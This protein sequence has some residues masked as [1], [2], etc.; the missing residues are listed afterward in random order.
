MTR[1]DA[2]AMEGP[3]GRATSTRCARTTG[4]SGDP[5]GVT[6]IHT[7]AWVEFLR[8][9]GSETHRAVRQL[10]EDDAPVHTTDVVVMEGLGWRS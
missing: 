6:L 4:W 2:L 1:E 9:A 7:S 3:A 10:L 5:G 8:G